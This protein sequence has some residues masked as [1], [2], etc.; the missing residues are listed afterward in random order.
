[1]N[2]K[3]KYFSKNNKIERFHKPYNEKSFKK[4]RCLKS[5]QKAEAYLEPTRASTMELFV[6]ILN[7]FIF[8][9]YKLHHRS[10]TR[11]YIGL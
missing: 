7:G 5:L 4:I 10:S 8:S 11:L 3:K 6:N 1:M 9:Q 2:Q